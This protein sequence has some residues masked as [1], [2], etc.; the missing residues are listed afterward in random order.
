[1][2][3]KY[4]KMYKPALLNHINENIK[5]GTKCVSLISSNTPD[6]HS[7]ICSEMNTALITN[8]RLL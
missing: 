6:L 2:V 3:V 7:V 5:L 1:M 4:F 8:K